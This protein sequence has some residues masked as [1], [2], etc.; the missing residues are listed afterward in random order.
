MPRASK[1]CSAVAL[2]AVS[3]SGGMLQVTV[4][5]GALV[6]P[7]KTGSQRAVAVMAD[8][9]VI[10]M[11]SAVVEPFDTVP[12]ADELR[13]KSDS[14]MLGLPP[15][16][17]MFA[18][19]AHTLARHQLMTAVHRDKAADS[20]GGDAFPSARSAQRAGMDGV[21]NSGAQVMRQWFREKIN[22]AMDAVSSIAN[23][24][25]DNSVNEGGAQDARDDNIALPAREHSLATGAVATETAAAPAISAGPGP[26]RAAAAAPP[27][28]ARE[29]AATQVAASPAVDVQPQLQRDSVS[30]SAASAGVAHEE[31]MQSAVSPPAAHNDHPADRLNGV[32]P[33]SHADGAAPAA[34]S[35]GNP[36]EE[37]Q[38]CQGAGRVPMQT[39]VG[40]ISAPMFSFVATGYQVC[41]SALPPLLV[42]PCPAVMHPS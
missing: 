24:G 11:P 18:D 4:W 36:S 22:R 38:K 13:N 6:V 31:V 2:T 29:A 21:V 14:E 16:Q 10:G 5:Q 34:P 19:S 23:R 8:T 32:D 27:C 35:A 20:V 40:G 15:V 28:T 3:I 37:G 25:D 26:S 33:G 9:I 30:A 7:E 12:A 1:L 41:N 39:G 42:R 17:T